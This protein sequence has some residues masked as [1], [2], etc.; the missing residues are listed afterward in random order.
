MRE[1]VAAAEY[2]VDFSGEGGHEG[3]YDGCEKLD[4]SE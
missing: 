4:H 3:C 1:F 2:K